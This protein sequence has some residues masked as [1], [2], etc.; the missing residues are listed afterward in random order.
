MHTNMPEGLQLELDLA[1]I[2][3]G[4]ENA[5]GKVLWVGKSQCLQLQGCRTL[6]QM[7]Y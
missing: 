1:H 4:G 2:V 6:W 3:L 7:K 5:I